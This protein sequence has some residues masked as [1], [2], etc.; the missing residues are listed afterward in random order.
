MTNRPTLHFG[1]LAA[2]VGIVAAS[3]FWWDARPLLPFKLLAVM[4]HET[5]HALSSLLV[6][7][8]VQ[9]VTLSVDQS[10]ACLSSIPDGFFPKV[11]VYSGGYVGSAI[12]AV[13]L[14]ALT[15]R[16]SAGRWMLGLASV[17]LAVMG[18]VYARDVFTFGFCAGF[19]VLF[20]A[21]ARWLPRDAVDA[22]NVFIAVFT[23]L[24]A[25]LDLRD[26]LWNGAVRVHSDAQLLADLTIV[27]AIVWAALWTMLSLAILAVGAWQA[28]Q[29]RPTRPAPLEV[30][31]SLRRR[32]R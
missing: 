15:F 19:A 16:F 32:S 14:L 11:L 22:V 9:K 24:Y 23:G 5:G 1:R 27:P 13:L 28:V 17:W 6:G 12:I 21:G 29:T 31:E 25:A 10:G 3:L 4:G 8:S 26:D 30:A 20:A 2:L 7:G 18:L